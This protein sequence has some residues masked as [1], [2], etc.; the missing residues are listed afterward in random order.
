[1]KRVVQIGLVVALFAAT[2][3]GSGGVEVSGTV[4]KDGKQYTL[5]EGENINIALQGDGATGSATV[6]Q[7]GSFTAKRSDGKPLPP[8]S[9]KISVTR[10]TAAAGGKGPP[11]RPDTKNAG[12]TWDVSSSNKTFT[13][14][15]GK[16]VSPAPEPKK[17]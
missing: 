17:K 6:S 13:L 1:M 2:G 12:E 9:Y 10:Y 16:Y 3:C 14:D 8:G 5:A 4:T 7:D 15:L 11:S